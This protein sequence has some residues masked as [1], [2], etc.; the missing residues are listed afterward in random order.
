V[1]MLVPERAFGGAFV[2][3]LR[4]A[5]GDELGQERVSTDHMVNAG[6]PLPD[7]WVDPAG[8]WANPV[9]RAGRIAARIVAS[10][11]QEGLYPVLVTLRDLP[12]ET[13]RIVIGWDRDALRQPDAPA[14]YVVAADGMRQSERRRYDW[15]TSTIDQ[16]RAA[17][18][19]A[20][21][22][23]ADDHALLKPGEEYTVSVRWR[24]AFSTD[25][26]QP[27]AT[28]DP[29]WQPEETQK[30]R[31]R[32]VPPEKAPDDLSPWILATTP[33]MDDVGVFRRE[34]VRFSFATQKV[35]A[36]FDAYGR[37][38]RVAVRAASGHHPEPPTGGGPGAAFVI[39]VT[40]TAPYGALAATFGVKTPWQEAVLEML[41][42]TGQ[43]CVATSGSSTYT[44]TLTLDYDFEPLTDYLID[45]HSVPKGASANATGLVYRVG[46][47]T[48]R[49]ASAGELAGFLEPSAVEHRVL[50]APAPIAALPG[51]PTGAQL[52][53][54]FQAAGLAVPQVPAFPKVQVLWTADAVPEPFA[55]VVESSEPL[56]RSRIVPTEIPAPADSPDPTHKYWAGRPADW[57]SLV[58]SATPPAAGDL[59]RATVT[60]IVR[61]P[62][63]TR[64][65][66]LLAP[67]SRG[68]EVRLDLRTAAD[69]LAGTPASTVTTARVSLL[70]APWEVED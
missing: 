48:S 21:T 10:S 55:V 18:S 7:G 44:Y 58:A 45:I 16:D 31:F 52:D 15:D 42:E 61:G 39:P 60:R 38:L 56:W 2:L 67:G 53:E 32:A 12:E 57:L 50:P 13:S 36:L 64:A 23:A 19:N 5:Q 70:R 3:S 59:P 6:N 47:T 65:V 54:A 20:L 27:N 17:L 40:A 34:K 46:F 25:E 35:A 43:N 9:Q 33:G 26:D 24:A 30:F 28:P 4:T 62:G 68:A 66:A 37:E 49:F 69:G 1:L 11:K 51:A 14:F 22:Q 29:T 8:P 41:E 63:G